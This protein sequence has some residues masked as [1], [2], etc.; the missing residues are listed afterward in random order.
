ERADVVN[1]HRT[2]C[3]R[4]GALSHLHVLGLQLHASFLAPAWGMGLCG[5][6]D[7]RSREALTESCPLEG[8][9]PYAKYA[10]PRPPSIQRGGPEATERVNRC[11]DPEGASAPGKSPVPHVHTSAGTSG[12]DQMDQ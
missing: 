10:P 3:R 12:D 11:L 7:H 2:A 5:A 6:R 4:L 9:A 1:R 8:G